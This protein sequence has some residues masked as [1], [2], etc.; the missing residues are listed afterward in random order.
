MRLRF[1][2]GAGLSINESAFPDSIPTITWSKL[3]SS[4]TPIRPSRSRS[5]S[6]IGNSKS[7]MNDASKV[8]RPE[9]AMPKSQSCFFFKLASTLV[10]LLSL[11]RLGHIVRLWMGAVL[12]YISR[13]NYNPVY[14][15]TAMKGLCDVI[16]EDF[17]VK[18][19]PALEFKL[20]LST[21]LLQ[22]HL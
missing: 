3:D 19:L 4:L 7:A 20:F 14:S 6:R 5:R 1:S 2:A 13:A 9:S 16:N 17:A 15:C 18:T 12:Q 10:D 11:R 8:G 21:T 22:L